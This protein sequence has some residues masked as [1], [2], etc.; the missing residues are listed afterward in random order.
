MKRQNGA[1]PC[2]STIVFDLDGTL[3]DTAPDLT[4]ALNAVL[5]ARGRARVTPHTVRTMVGHGA[6]AMIRAGFSATGE[7]AREAE[8]DELLTLFLDHYSANLSRL[9]RP[10]PGLL[11]LL[12]TLMARGVRLGVCTNKREALSIALLE[13]LDLKRYF[14]VVLGADSLPVRK[15]HPDHLLGTIAAL[16]GDRSDAL[17]VGDSETDLATARAAGVPVLLVGFGYSPVPARDLGADAT[18]DHFDAFLAALPG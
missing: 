1:P 9:S 8:M 2:P 4:E 6:P 16:G 13:A 17:M 15:P 14:P 12:D 7:A 18:I 11:P 10:F 5:E 3:V